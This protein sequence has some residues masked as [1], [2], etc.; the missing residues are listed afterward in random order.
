[1]STGKLTPLSISIVGVI[2]LALLVDGLDLQLL[3]LVAPVVLDEW[4]I[5]RLTFG[6]AMSAALI[7]V[8]AGASVG[9]WLGDRFGRKQVLLWSVV[10]FGAATVATSFTQN[11]TE[12][13]ALRLLGGLGFGAAGPNGIA[14]ANE[15]VPPIWRPRVTSMLTMGTPLGGM[16]GAVAVPMV[17]PTVGWR[18]SFVFCGAVSLLL[19]A[20]VYFFVRESPEFRARAENASA[21][22]KDQSGIASILAPQY[23]R[24]NIGAWTCYFFLSVVAYAIAAWSPV[25]LTAAG[26]SLNQAL[27]AVIVFNLCAV[28]AA[29]SA[30]FIVTVVGSRN[31]IGACCAV[32]LI[33]IL[34]L[35]L[36]I[37]RTAE[38]SDAILQ[39]RVSM[40]AIGATT[41]T[42]LAMMSAIL[43]LAYPTAIRS[44]GLGLGGMMGRTGGI[45]IAMFGGALLSFRG[46]DPSLLFVTLG[47]STVIAFVA[48]LTID[49]HIPA[50]TPGEIHS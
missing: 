46:D 47:I 13:T 49:R 44:T 37:V 29:I 32:L 38:G 27:S 22:G 2:M 25:F 23:K 6:P 20:F 11:V 26:L 8:A 28:I 43:A 40:G 36:A 12:L 19:A 9:G 15:W 21:A 16:L 31:L 1:L 50:R 17:L 35:Y 30:G 24:L 14:L 33:A 18:G 48:M 7:G 10:W 3:S 41:G 42:S 5:S 39:V 34:V 4:K 45:V